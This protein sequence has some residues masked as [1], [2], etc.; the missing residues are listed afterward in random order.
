SRRAALLSRYGCPARE[1]EAT[2][3]RGHGYSNASKRLLRR[4]PPAGA[5][6]LVASRQAVSGP[7]NPAQ[8]QLTKF[9]LGVHFLVV[10]ADGVKASSALVVLRRPDRGARLRAVG[11]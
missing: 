6:S 8:H 2:C 9:V 5:E 11:F 7:Q 4:P 3:T 1:L 10:A